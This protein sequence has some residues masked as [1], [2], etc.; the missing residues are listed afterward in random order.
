MNFKVFGALVDSDLA[1]ASFLSLLLFIVTVLFCFCWK[2]TRKKG[3]FGRAREGFVPRFL[4]LLK[5][6][7]WVP[8]GLRDGGGSGAYHY[9]GFTGV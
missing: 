1:Y 4:S 9:D 7:Y 6:G 8:C 5:H 3:V 2:G